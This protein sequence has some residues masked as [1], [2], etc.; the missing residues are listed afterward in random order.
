MEQAWLGRE[1]PVKRRL[2]E[3]RREPDKTHIGEHPV[4]R[5]CENL[6]MLS[7]DVAEQHYMLRIELNS[8]VNDVMGLPTIGVLTGRRIVNRLSSVTPLQPVRYRVR[9]AISP[10]RC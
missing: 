8:F 10:Q 9:A 4:E 6:W 2:D 7:D 3:H 1:R 5:V